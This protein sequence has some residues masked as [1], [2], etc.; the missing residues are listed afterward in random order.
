MKLIVVLLAERKL[1]PRDVILTAS[2]VLF[3][4]FAF[5]TNEAKMLQAATGFHDRAP[6]AE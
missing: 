5:A 6:S 4:M 3:D 1:K 2:V